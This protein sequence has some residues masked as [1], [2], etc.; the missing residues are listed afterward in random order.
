MVSCCWWVPGDLFSAEPT[1]APRSADSPSPE[2]LDQ[3][4]LTLATEDPSLPGFTIICTWTIGPKAPPARSPEQAA[5]M[6][7]KTLTKLILDLQVLLSVLQQSAQGRSL[8]P[9]ERA[10]DGSL[11]LIIAMAVEGPLVHVLSL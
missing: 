5:R 6:C 1:T 2:R 11:Q 3:L 10:V 7:G 9:A 8:G 4:H